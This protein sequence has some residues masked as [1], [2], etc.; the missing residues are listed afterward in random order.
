M[1]DLAYKL[2]NTLG[3]VASLMLVIAI[4]D[5]I[6]KTPKNPKR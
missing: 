4:Y 3:F 5:A 1:E 2:F 6:V